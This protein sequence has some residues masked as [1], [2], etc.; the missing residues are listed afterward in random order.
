[1]LFVFK[2]KKKIGVV[3]IAFEVKGMTLK[4]NKSY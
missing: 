2:L 4:R 1:M 3:I